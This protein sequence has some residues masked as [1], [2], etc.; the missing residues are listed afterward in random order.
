MKKRF[1]DKTELLNYVEK[2]PNSKNLENLEILLHLDSYCLGDTICFSSYIK[3]FLEYHKPKKIVV[4]TFFNELFESWDDRIIFTN[5][6]QSKK[7]EVDKLINVGYD[8][9]NLYHTLNGMFYAARDSMML[10]L[11]IKYDKPPVKKLER[12]INP[13]K[14][15]IGPESIKKIAR[16]EYKNGWQTVVDYLISNNFIIYNVSYENNIKLNNVYNLNNY[17]LD[18]ALQH[19]LQSRIFIGLS[20]GLS[21]LAWAYDVPVVMIS[22]FTKK[23]N[24]FEC[25]RVDNSYCC[26]GCFNVFTNITNNC[27][28]F[29][30]T[31]RENECHNKITPIM[32]IKK[33]NEALQ[34]T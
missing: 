30:N 28:I 15:T 3:T 18:V 7:I 4:S 16:W 11:E 27:P 1:Y 12:K 10:P 25:F 33:I 31:P 23:H 9:K 24:E 22:N 20:S 6:N 19:I 5:A 13:N 14:I 21:W 2:N 8:K 34:I 29:L 32:V 26:Y 17:V